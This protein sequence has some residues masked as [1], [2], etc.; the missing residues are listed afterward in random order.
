MRMNIVQATMVKRAK[1]VATG[2]PKGDDHQIDAYKLLFV[3]S[4]GYLSDVR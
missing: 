3:T 4:I 2:W 1:I